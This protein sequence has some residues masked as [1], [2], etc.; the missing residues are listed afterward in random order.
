MSSMN[1][2]LKSLVTSRS[3]RRSSNNVAAPNPTNTTSPPPPGSSPSTQASSSSTS[4]PMNP[5]GLG[6]PPS[7]S[8]TQAPPG[9]GGLGAPPQH[10]GRPTSPLPPLNTGQ[11]HYP[12]QA[13]L[14]QQPPPGPPGYPAQ[15]PPYA[16]AY[17]GPPPAAAVQPYQRPGAV[18]VE[19][20]G[21]SKAQLI[22]GIDFVSDK[23]PSATSI[24]PLRPRTDRCPRA[25]LSPALLLRLRRIQRRKKISLPNGLARGIK[26]NR[27]YGMQPRQYLIYF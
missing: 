12:P 13:P 15:Q 22:V 5:H 6:R 20:A 27:R 24:H 3:S 19:G 1:A 7:Y 25:Q 18:E 10:G 11:S 4:L 23:N 26:P 14:Y 21:R 17:G 9:Q 8:Y 2:R 16:G